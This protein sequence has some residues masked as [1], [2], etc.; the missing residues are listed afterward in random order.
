MS[1]MIR[2][3]VLI[4]S[5]LLFT[6]CVYYNTFYNAKLK[7]KQAEQNQFGKDK[8]PRSSRGA[9]EINRAGPPIEPS[10]SIGEKTLYKSAIEKATKVVV[11]HPESKYVDDALWVIG[12]SRYNITEYIASDKK[13]RE[14]VVRFPQSEYA[15]DAYYY[16]G[17]GQFWM[18]KYDAALES[19]NQVTESKN[20]NYRDDA[21]FNIA[22]MD[23]INENYS[24][25]IL[26]FEEFLKEFPKS[27]SAATAQFFIGVCKDSLDEF[28]GAI[29]AYNIVDKYKPSHE[30]YFDSRFAY[31]STALKADSIKLGMSVFEDLS[32]QERYFERSSNIRLKIAEGMHL[33]GKTEDA[34]AEYMKVIEQFPRTNQSA[35]AYYRLGLIYQDTKDDLVKA[36]EYYND[37]TKEKR[38]SPFYHLALTKSANITKLETY[39][40]KLDRD[41]PKESEPNDTLQPDS[42]DIES[43]Q[44]DADSSLEQIPQLTSLMPDTMDFIGDS[45]QPEIPSLIRRMREGADK[46]GRLPIDS[47]SMPPFAPYVMGPPAPKDS[48]SMPLFKPY[49]MGPPAPKDSM[50]MPSFE[51]Y[52]MGPPAPKDSV[53]IF[54]RQDDFG[55]IQ[56]TLTAAEIQDSLDNIAFQD[57]IDLVN[58]DIEIRFLLAE[59]YHHDLNRP[60]SALQEYLMLV[61]AYPESEYAPKALLASALIYEKN[62][63]STNANEMYLRLVNTYQSSDQARFAVSKIE[64]AQIPPDQDVE[65]LYSQA[66]DMYFNRSNPDSAIA[67]FDF[68]EKTFP[69]SEYS[70]KSAFAKAWVINA[71]IKVDG[72]SSSFHEFTSFLEKYPE[73]AY[74][75][76]VK[77]KLG[78]IKREIPVVHQQTSEEDEGLSPEED[79]LRRVEA[80][81]LRKSAYT[82]PIAPAVKDTGVFTWP[83]SLLRE[84]FKRTI[85][86]TYKVR[87]DLFG[88]VDEFQLL[89]P[90]GLNEIDSLANV[91]LKNTIFDMDDLSDLAMIDGFFRYDMKLVP[92]DPR[93]FWDDPRR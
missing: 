26:S 24:S 60:D 73:S 80:D 83:D 84:K 28:I 20:S 39:R 33:M 89:G 48:M 1:N 68:I 36:K 93:D 15:D 88:N 63:D 12:K 78:I 43:I 5:F 67:I 31:G 10:I 62:K 54:N 82:L 56:D 7:F 32:K 18:K 57:S 9:T 21:A 25:A 52:I 65:L 71:E 81:S 70:I 42:T 51:P 74:T 41:V 40:L 16:I 85:T 50:L 75:E 2:K 58:E 86:I 77:I 6:S 34:E 72:D 29:Q 17:M 44:E 76:D 49:V 53:D 11:Y 92:P 66:E 46:D 79:S 90:S 23:F 30:L 27:D 19:F 22:Y 4:L 37:A 59:L 91:A 38:D 35:E 14:L 3:S 47:M 87:L 13:F 69:Q 55:R 61:E 64:G 8:K 45:N